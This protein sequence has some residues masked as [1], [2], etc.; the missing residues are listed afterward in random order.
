MSYHETNLLQAKWI[1]NIRFKVRDWKTKI[2]LGILTF[3]L[4]LNFKQLFDSLF[5][6]YF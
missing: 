6:I 2:K 5:F 4:I 1:L 3:D